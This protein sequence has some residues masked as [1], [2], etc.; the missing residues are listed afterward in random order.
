MKKILL[1]A[2]LSFALGSAYAQTGSAISM[3]SATSIADAFGTNLTLGTDNSCT[4]YLS[5]DATYLYF[6]WSGGKTNYSSDLYYIGIDTDPDGSNGNT[7]NIQGATFSASN[8]KKLDYYIYYENNSTFG[9]V[10][11]TGGNSLE[12]WQNSGG[13]WSF[14]NRTTADDGSSSQVEFLDAG[15]NIRGRVTWAALGFTPGGS[16]K[17]GIIMWTNNASGDF[18]WSSFPSSNPIGSTNQQ[19]TDYLVFNSTGSGVNTSSDGSSSP[20]PVEL[21]GFAGKFIDGKVTLNWNTATEKNNYG[22]EV[23]RGIATGGDENVRFTKLGFVEGNGTS[24]SPKSYSYTDAVLAPGKY[25]YRLKQI[26]TDGKFEYSREIEVS[27]ENLV[28]DFVLEQNYPNPFNP[29]TIV[30]FGL[31]YEAKVTMSVYTITGE[32]VAVLAYG[33]F[34]AG[35]HQATFAASNMPSGMYICRIQA[36]SVDG[37]HQFTA[38]RKMMLLK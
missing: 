10:P 3:N 19:L 24:N 20:L 30:R 5:W 21:T 14:V 33:I 18:I 22:F 36:V 23:E 8:S 27:V 11:T 29:S 12:M 15:G 9:G 28:N 1:L 17:I 38:S 6:G 34:T 7:A 31:P 32:E 4:Y 13:S 16:T 35:N 26:D 25:I 37:K 2:F